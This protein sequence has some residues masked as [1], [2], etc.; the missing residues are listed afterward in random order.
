MFSLLLDGHVFPFFSF[1]LLSFPFLLSDVMLR[2]YYFSSSSGISNAQTLG[3][4]T[5]LCFIFKCG[6]ILSFADQKLCLVSRSDSR[7][8]KQRR[9]ER[10]RSKSY[11]FPPSLSQPK[12]VQPDAF[13]GFNANK[14]VD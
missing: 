9:K 1:P 11:D 14:N 8:G 7:S 10:R 12:S 13:Q 5:Y 6:T 2:Y 3:L 4:G